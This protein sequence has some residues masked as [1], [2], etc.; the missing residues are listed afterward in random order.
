M[1][2]LNPSKNPFIHIGDWTPELISQIEVIVSQPVETTSDFTRKKSPTKRYWKS[3]VTFKYHTFESSIIKMNGCDIPYLSKQT[4]G[5]DYVYAVINQHVAKAIE[6][7]GIKAEL[8]VDIED[9]KVKSNAEQ[10]WKTINKLNDRFGSINKTG[11]FVP[12]S[13]P[14]IFNKTQSGLKANFDMIFNLKCNTD[15]GIDRTARTVFRLTP[16]ASRCYIKQL[17]VDVQPPETDTSVP[18]QKATR[19]DIA[20][21]DLLAELD[22]LGI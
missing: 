9:E 19:G 21:D 6:A 17:N 10:C 20:D 1:S 5:K 14:G 11:Q 4:Y 12:R 2:A 8:T 7:A 13:L 18:L 3:T 15:G 22:N 16:E